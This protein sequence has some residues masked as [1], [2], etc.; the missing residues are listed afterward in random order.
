MSKE[1]QRSP[2]LGFT[3][4]ISIKEGEKWKCYIDGNAG[5]EL[6]RVIINLPSSTHQK[7]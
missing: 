6:E 1:N 7:V 4:P 5:G 2:S 3:Y